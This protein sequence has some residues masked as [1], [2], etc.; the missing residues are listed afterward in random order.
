MPIPEEYEVRDENGDLLYKE[1]LLIWINSVPSEFH[2][3]YSDLDTFISFWENL[4]T[5]QK[6]G[7]KSFVV[8]LLTIQGNKI[9]DIITE[10]NSL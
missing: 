10:I 5:A 2:R 9:S 3:V 8:N 1:S 6:T 4:T 7:I